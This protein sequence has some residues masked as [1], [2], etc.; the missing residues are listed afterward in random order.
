MASDLEKNQPIV[1][2]RDG[3]VFYTYANRVDLDW[4]AHDIRLRFSERSLLPRDRPGGAKERIE[5]RASIALSWSQAK[6][7]RDLLDLALDHYEKLNGPIINPR[8]PRSLP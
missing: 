6:A 5:E 8:V 4:T 7:L 2:E 1:V 3:G